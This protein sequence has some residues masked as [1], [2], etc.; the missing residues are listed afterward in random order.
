MKKI[1]WRRNTEKDLS[2]EGTHDQRWVIT[3]EKIKKLALFQPESQKILACGTDGQFESELLKEFPQLEIQ[4]SDWDLRNEFPLAPGGQDFC[5]ALEVV[6]HL[7]DRDD[8]IHDI[9]TH[10]FTGLMSFLL[11]SHKSLKSGGLL[12]LTTPN[13]SSFDTIFRTIQGKSNFMYWPHVR[14]LS[15]LELSYFLNQT[16]YQVNVI[17]TFSP[18]QNDFRAN[19]AHLLFLDIFRKLLKGDP[20]M[21]NMRGSTLFVVAQ[22]VA[23]PKDVLLETEWHQVKLTDFRDSNWQ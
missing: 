5:I 16:G 10:Y 13:S 12:I 9:A 6:E 4:I 18:Y 7:K 11:E 1:Q 14:E 22:K 20:S 19:R 8:V 17:E 23:T 15:P 3:L 21:K 2:Y